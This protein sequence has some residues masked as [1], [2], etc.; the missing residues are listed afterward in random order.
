MIAEVLRLVLGD[1]VVQAADQEGQ[2]AIV[3]L[4]NGGRQRAVLRRRQVL[5]VD[6]QRR[7]AVH[8]EAMD[9][10]DVVF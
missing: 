6:V 10:G 3:V 2:K 7:Q 4:R 1:H 9:L 5:V 8:A